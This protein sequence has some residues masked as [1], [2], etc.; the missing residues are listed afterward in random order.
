MDGVARETQAVGME[1]YENHSAQ[2]ETPATRGGNRLPRSLVVLA[3]LVVALLAVPL[4]ASF[5]TFTAS[6]QEEYAGITRV[7]LRLAASGNVRIIGSDDDQVKVERTVRGIMGVATTVD[8]RQ[9]G[10]TLRLRTRCPLPVATL[11]CGRVGY[12]LRV[13]TDTELAGSAA[14]GSVTVADVDGAVDLSTSNGTVTLEGGASPIA[15]RTSNGSIEVTG[16]RAPWVDLKT[17]N[18][19][20]SLASETAPDNVTA[21][22]SNGR[23]EILVP[24]DAPPYAVATDTA[25]GSVDVTVSTDASAP[26][27]IEART[28]NGAITVGHPT[29]Q[30]AS[31]GGSR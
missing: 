6:T 23:I 30:R 16:T 17:S 24:S 12:T 29:E 5:G 25:N 2:G 4:S 18:G 14:N 27:T 7:D 20:I 19:G 28:S 22:T 10:E 9:E 11:T 3:V 21:R 8:E 15:L 1:P 13:P 26:R 31:Q